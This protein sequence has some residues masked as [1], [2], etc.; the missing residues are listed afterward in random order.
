MKA[1]ESQVEAFDWLYMAPVALVVL[2]LAGPQFLADAAKAW[3]NSHQWWL[4]VPSIMWFF[5]IMFWKSFCRFDDASIELGEIKDAKPVLQLDCDPSIPGCEQRVP[6]AP[7]S[8]KVLRVRVSSVG[9]APQV[10]DVKP[11]MVEVWRGTKRLDDG[12]HIPLAFQPSEESDSECKT[13]VNDSPRVIDVVFIEL[14]DHVFTRFLVGSKNT[15]CFFSQ[16]LN[17]WLKETGHYTLVVQCTGRDATT[18]SLKT[19]LEVTGDRWS[20]TLRAPPKTPSS[21]P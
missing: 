1:K 2:T 4:L 3:A 19:T 13:I 17:E 9:G 18:V 8:V 21:I 5:G 11:Y 6:M 15:E 16:K 20:S 14:I 10:Y 12:D 7:R